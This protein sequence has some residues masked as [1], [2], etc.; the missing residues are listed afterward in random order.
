MKAIFGGFSAALKRSSFSCGE[1]GMIVAHSIPKKRPPTTISAY[2]A[3]ITA[4]E[5]KVGQLM[6][7]VELLLYKRKAMASIPNGAHGS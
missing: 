2:E 6:M 1:A 7:E 4:L 5:R 3:K